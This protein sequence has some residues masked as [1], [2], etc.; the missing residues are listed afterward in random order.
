MR[1]A[2]WIIARSSIFVGAELLRHKDDSPRR[3]ESAFKSL[4]RKA[5]IV[6]PAGFMEQKAGP[7]SGLHMGGEPRSFCP[8]PRCRLGACSM[9]I[10]RYRLIGKI[11]LPAA[12][13]M[14]PLSLTG[15]GWGK[16]YIGH[17]PHPV[18]PGGAT[19]RPR[20]NACRPDR[21]CKNEPVR[22]R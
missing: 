11:H 19:S 20:S 6:R 16:R 8:K 3:R 10:L 18:R 1:M 13:I 2:E 21:P 17:P 14:H 4:P 15:R 12:G 22:P 9:M 7:M 5:K